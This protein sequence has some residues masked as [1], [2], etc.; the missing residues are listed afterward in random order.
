MFRDWTGMDWCLDYV[1]LLVLLC[2]CVSKVCNAMQ[3]SYYTAGQAATVNLWLHPQDKQQN[4]RKILHCMITFRDLFFFKFRKVEKQ[5]R[6]ITLD[7]LTA[8][9]NTNRSYSSKQVYRSCKS[10]L[11]VERGKSEVSTI[12]K[13]VRTLSHSVE[14][15]KIINFII[16]D[17][18]RNEGF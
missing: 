10:Q 14:A 6:E 3:L 12:L 18:L 5:W 4:C 1:E 9:R 16:E 7:I 15:V 2:V 11:H 13:H 8:K 17:F